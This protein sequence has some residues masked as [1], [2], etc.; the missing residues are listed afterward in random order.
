MDQQAPRPA[1]TPPTGPRRQGRAWRAGSADC[2]GALCLVAMPPSL[3]TGPNRANLTGGLIV[4][5][6]E[7]H[8]RTGKGR[9]EKDH[10]DDV[11]SVDGF[12]EGPDREIDWGMVDDELHNHFNELLGAMGR[13][14]WTAA[15]PTS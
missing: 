11:V 1:F 15:S 2:S 9:D 8:D 6:D 7:Y 14:P 10:L 5:P 4:T 3:P 12:F 13:L